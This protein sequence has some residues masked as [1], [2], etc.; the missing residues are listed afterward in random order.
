M[1]RKSN[2]KQ[3]FLYIILPYICI[4]ILHI[5]L[6]MQISVPTIWPDEFINYFSARYLINN[7]IL[8]KL[9]IPINDLIGNLGYS[10]LISP[11][12]IFF[13]EPLNA[14]K[15]SL[16]FNA[17][18]GSTI[19]IATFLFVKTIFKSDY[20]KS[21]LIS[22]IVSLYPAFI[23]QTNNLYSDAI[24]PTIFLFGILSIYYLLKKQNI[25]S[26]ILFVLSSTLIVLINIRLIPFPIISILF[27][28]YISFK[29][30]FRISLTLSIII[31][32]IILITLCVFLEDSIIFG[33]SGLAS[34]EFKITSVLIN[35]FQLT[36]L[37][38]SIYYIVY[39]FCSKQYLYS[40]FTFIGFITG[41]L[42]NNNEFYFIITALGIFV[43]LLFKMVKL[44]KRMI[45]GISISL[46][47]TFTFYIILP[48]YL[49][50][51]ELFSIIKTWIVN[52]SGTVYYVFISTFLL[53]FV[54]LVFIIIHLWKHS[55]NIPD[56][57]EMENSLEIEHK[58]TY[59]L[60]RIITEPR[61]STLFLF[62]LIS[63]S[64]LFVSIYPSLYSDDF[65]RADL[66]FYGRNIELILAGFLAYA[67][68]C[69]RESDPKYYL[70]AIV[71]TILFFSFFTIILLLNYNNIIKTE[72]SFKSIIGFFPFRAIIGN[73]NIFLFSTI[74]FIIGLMF[75][76]LHRYKPIIT[77]III[78]SIYLFASLFTYNYVDLYTNNEKINRT[79]IVDFINKYFPKEDQIDYDKN[80][81]SES[82][83]NGLSYAFHLWNRKI[84]F[85]D[86]SEFK[87]GLLIS[88]ESF[89]LKDHN[90]YV[91]LAI[92]HDGKDYLWADKERLNNKLVEELIPSYLDLPLTES[93]IG[94]ISKIGFLKD[95][96]IK[97]NS[98]F[99]IPLRKQDSVLSISFVI[100]S[101]VESKATLK[102]K[103][104]SMDTSL[105]V[106]PGLNE[107]NIETRYNTI[108]NY[109]TIEFICDLPS[110]KS[111]KDDKYY[112]LQLKSLILSDVK[113]ESNE[114][115]NLTNENLCDISK[116]TIQLRP[117]IDLSLFKP[118]INDSIKIPI[119]L[120]NNGISNI[121]LNKDSFQISY[122]WRDFIFKSIYSSKFQNL[123][124]NIVIYPNSYNEQFITI[125][126]PKEEKK[127]FLEFGLIDNRN[128]WIKIEKNRKLL[129]NLK[130]K[131]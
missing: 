34:P 72:A 6:A 19:Y 126:F 40:Y 41:I 82:S 50:F 122:K 73:I 95:F 90:R 52:L 119:R 97:H 57:H 101:N 62:L 33:I 79:I 67:L 10:I 8:T 22:I 58:K 43:P 112:G 104:S 3:V 61:H 21:S 31:A 111:K 37:F 39:F 55:V 80:N 13:Q 27:L 117:N 25:L 29:K 98:K 59:T 28:I 96:W 17:L 14:F 46:I 123:K 75:I 118:K 20:K 102:I 91:L 44:N 56:E 83:Q 120:I 92:E 86:T 125:Y 32:L 65:Y 18:V 36:L 74:A 77:T 71:S 48:D 60:I 16:L 5:I 15:A 103:L 42:S 7:D 81:Y 100:Y 26:S 11:I 12:F 23:L 109:C 105:N 2:F 54:G 78:S 35:I 70:I 106:E 108:S 110:Y 89:G 51:S 68:Y 47:V 45:Y 76:I 127:F 121:F 24:A 128:N 114:G 124:E 53:F 1:K 129:F 9:I 38:F 49:T 64:C 115:Y 131:I 107:F 116:L 113:K 30:K 99:I 84:N 130:H 85:I 4:A 87:S 93:W 88:S 69:L 66:L 94:G 63:L